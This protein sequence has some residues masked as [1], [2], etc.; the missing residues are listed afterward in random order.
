[1]PKITSKRQI[2]LPIDQCAVAQI[3]IG[4][5]VNSFVDRQGIISIVKKS[6]GIASGFLKDIKVDNTISDEESL[7]DALSDRR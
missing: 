7:E 3:N 1:M 4:D 2:T 5:E 6:K